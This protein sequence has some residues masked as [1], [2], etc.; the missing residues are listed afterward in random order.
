M[1]LLIWLF[2]NNFFDIIAILLFI[3]IRI[4]FFIKYFWS[5]RIVLEPILRIFIILF[6]FFRFFYVSVLYCRIGFYIMWLMNRHPGQSVTYQQIGRYSKPLSYIRV[7]MRIL[8]K[9][10]K[11]V[12]KKIVRIIYLIIFIIRFFFYIIFT[13]KIV[14]ISNN[15]S[16]IYLDLNLFTVLL[17]SFAYNIYNRFHK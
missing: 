6:N 11:A 13:D 14:Y 3:I 17:P 4:P 9:M 8:M 15:I 16:S 10:P 7:Y 5:I 1:L 12:K 2:F